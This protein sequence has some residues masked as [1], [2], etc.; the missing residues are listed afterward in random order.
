MSPDR[1]ARA[2]MKHAPIPSSGSR[3]RVQPR[4]SA[5]ACCGQGGELAWPPP[6]V[7]APSAGKGFPHERIIPGDILDS[8][9]RGGPEYKLA[10]GMRDPMPRRGMFQLAV[11]Y[12]ARAELEARTR[13]LPVTS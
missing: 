5:P 2:P 8:E 1:A 13:R 9:S 6:R 3:L 7:S 11:S 4:I 10:I 12:D